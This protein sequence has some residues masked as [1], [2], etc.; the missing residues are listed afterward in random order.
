M[1]P[2]GTG[3]RQQ[4]RPLQEKAIMCISFLAPVTNEPKTFLEP[5]DL[6]EDKD[7]SFE[8]EKTEKNI[9]LR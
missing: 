4:G 8:M 3:P 7:G 2:K 6:R 1:S 5:L 9:K